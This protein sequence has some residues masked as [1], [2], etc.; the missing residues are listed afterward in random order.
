MSYVSSV[1][2]IPVSRQRPRNKQQDNS[3]CW[4]PDTQHATAKELLEAV[5]SVGLSATVA[6]QRRCKHASETTVEL[7]Q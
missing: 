2:Y 3:R 5:F 1:A 7:Q 4:A 6:M